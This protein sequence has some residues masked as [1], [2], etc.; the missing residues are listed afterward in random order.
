MSSDLLNAFDK[1]VQSID[2][3]L[4]YLS[5]YPCLLMGISNLHQPLLSNP[6]M[7]KSL[8]GIGKYRQRPGG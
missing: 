4:C 3:L 6:G 8:K 5:M 2:F 1:K 7:A